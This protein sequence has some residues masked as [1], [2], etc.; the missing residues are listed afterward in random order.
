MHAFQDL[1]LYRIAENMG[2]FSCIDD[3]EGKNN[4]PIK[5]RYSM[6]RKLKREKFGDWP[7]S[8]QIC[9]CFLPPM[10]STI[11]YCFWHN[12]NCFSLF[13]VVTWT[14]RVHWTT[15]TTRATRKTQETRTPLVSN[16]SGC[17]DPTN[18]RQLIFISQ[19]IP[20]IYKLILR[21]YVL[22]DYCRVN[23]T[24]LAGSF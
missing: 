13:I 7:S 1:L 6:F 3:L 18:S 14:T 15:R 12:F 21:P 10:F 9:Q 11:Y 8:C 19:V 23:G 16:T 22:N 17:P 5:C 24:E 20:C 2:E 4:L